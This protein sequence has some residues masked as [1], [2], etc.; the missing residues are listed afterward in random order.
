VS[1]QIQP[2]TGAVSGRFSLLQ[3][4]STPWVFRAGNTFSGW[5]VRLPDGEVKAVG[6]FLLPQLPAAGQ[7]LRTSPVLSGAFE[8]R[9]STMP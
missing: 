1:L 9:Q 4:S 6:Y 7:T 8:F 2:T 5:I 3:T